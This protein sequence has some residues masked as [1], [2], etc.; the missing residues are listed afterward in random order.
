MNFD[1]PDSTA[2]ENTSDL[3][4]QCE[5]GQI[6]DDAC[7]QPTED[8]PTAIADCEDTNSCPTISAAKTLG[9]C[10]LLESQTASRII[11]YT[12]VSQ[13]TFLRENGEQ[14][15]NCSNQSQGKF[16]APHNGNNIVCMSQN[17]CEQLINKYLQ[18]TSGVLLAEP[19][20]ASENNFVRFHKNSGLC[21]NSN[22]AST[23]VFDEERIQ[24]ELDVL[25]G[26]WANN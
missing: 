18:N 3:G 5:I 16:L 25:A 10:Q 9:L 26:F 22:N 14:D 12:E 6:A 15:S 19:V 13:C 20:S 21:E 2:F 11:G 7:S 8:L 24:S 1:K 4:D 17:A 23:R